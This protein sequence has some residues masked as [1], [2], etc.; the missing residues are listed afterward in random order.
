M[1]DRVMVPIT[2]A[3][4]RLFNRDHIDIMRVVLRDPDRLAPAKDAITA[5]LRARHRIVPPEADDFDVV[6]P[7]MVAG[8][9]RRTQGT[10]GVLLLA[11]A[12]ISLLAGGIVVMNVMV[13][14]VRE[15]RREIGL[16]RAVGATQGDIRAQFLCEAAAV[17][18]LGGALGCGL[19]TG[20]AYLMR[21]AW[22]MPMLLTWEPYVL[23]ALCSLVV[24]LLFGAWPAR[25]AAR[26]PPVDALRG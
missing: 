13:V 23:A 17:T 10:F 5:L 14:S 8:M 24:G 19:G 9:V 7:D 20:A 1:D 25:T 4:R 12:G 21:V 18:L 15:R 2:T 16:R 26:L 22:K 3:M 6:T 11:L